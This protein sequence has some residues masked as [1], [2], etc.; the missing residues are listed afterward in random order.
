MSE[1]TNT[2][3]RAA[4]PVFTDDGAAMIGFADEGVRGYTPTPY[5]YDTY[6]DAKNAARLWN[7]RVGHTPERA[8]EIVL[9]TMTFGGTQ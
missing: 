3:T 6:D 8:A 7:E 1:H 2:A 4:V 9:S 5:T